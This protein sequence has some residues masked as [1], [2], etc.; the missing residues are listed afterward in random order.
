MSLARATLLL[1]LAEVV[2]TASGYA[3]NAILARTLDVADFGRYSLVLSLTTMAIVLIGRS[4]P[5]AMAKRISEAPHRRRAIVR[6]AAVLQSALIAALTA[7]F[8]A[9]APLIARALGD[10][11]LTEL[12][13]L[14]ALVI[15]AF[16]LSSFHVLYFNGLRR[17]GAQT[18]LKITRGIARLAWITILA[19]FYGVTGALTGAI[20]APLTVFAV[21]ILIDAFFPQRDDATP[22]RGLLPYPPRNLLTYAAGF[23]LFTLVYEVYLRMDI[24]LIKRIIATDAAVG[25][26]TA[27]MTIALIPYYLTV[28]LAIMLFPTIAKLSAEK[29]ARAERE[30]LLS[31]IL[32]FLLIVLIGSAGMIG[33]HASDL[34]T[35]LFGA[36]Y[37]PA[38]PLLLALIA[39]MIGATLFF[40]FAAALNGAGYT[41]ITATL[42]G[43]GIA[44][45]IVLDGI[46]LPIHGTIIAATTFS[47]TAL[48]MGGG[49]LYATK[50]LLGMR[51]PFTT[52]L[53]ATIAAGGALLTTLLHLPALLSIA[54]Y[55][56]AY[57]C[58]L[59]ALREIT[60]ADI[61]LLARRHSA[62]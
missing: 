13:R 15:P 48:V 47:I 59:F 23:A 26:Y 12:F 44:G 42:G 35:L 1:I 6:S 38:S 43:I 3:T 28:S 27:A 31:A 24:I 5:T 18:A 37:A 25:L 19:L 7:L 2:F 4:L 39:G 56:G 36:Q 22:A 52:F 49:A 8:Y 30:R 51:F 9:A 11:T 32:R 55:G 53:R 57:C 14:S 62:R 20:L 34:L 40:I 29:A 50:T 61:A 45:T 16:A 41:I 21:A 58:I 17:F 54:L 10:A 46:F 33:V 60:R